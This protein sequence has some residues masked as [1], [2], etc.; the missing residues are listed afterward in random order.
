MNGKPS[1]HITNY[2]SFYSEYVNKV[3]NGERLYLVETKT[4]LFKFFIDFDC[5]TEKKL[6][7][8]EILDVCRRVNQVVPGKC[9]CSV[10]SSKKVDK[11]IKSGIHIHFPDL[12]VTK[13]KALRIRDELPDDIKQFVDE[14]V[15]KGSGLRMLWSYKRDGGSPYVPFFDFETN[16]W[17][18]QQPS[19]EMLKLFSIKTE[20]TLHVA[21]TQTES[22]SNLESFIHRY[23]PGHENIH[24]KDISKNIIRTDSK[25]CSRIQR[26]HKSNHVYFVIDG[27]CIY[28][29]CYDSEC[30]KFSGRRYKLTPSALFDIK[31]LCAI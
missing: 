24:V 30:K 13:Q 4:P 31:T 21:E 16:T 20:Y 26:D 1:L 8:E 5:V 9:I 17:L 6:E 15:Y 23:I 27:M 10:S 11:G 14:S 19:V 18:D 22:F 3:K 28:Q 12:I 2:D 29:K 25:Y 7:R